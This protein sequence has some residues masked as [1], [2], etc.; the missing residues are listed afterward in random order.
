M[1]SVGTVP[2]AP[3]LRCAEKRDHWGEVGVDSMQRGTLPVTDARVAFGTR[4]TA[5]QVAGT[6]GLGELRRRGTPFVSLTGRG[7]TAGVP[8]VVAHQAGRR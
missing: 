3:D 4:A 5:C 1:E 7:R 8:R 6:R 2:G